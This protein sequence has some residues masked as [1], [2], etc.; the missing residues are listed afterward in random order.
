MSW[1]AKPAATEK[2][3]SPASMF[4]GLTDG[5]T[6]TIAAITAIESRSQPA[7]LLITAAKLGVRRTRSSRNRSHRTPRETR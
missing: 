4:T 7:S 5:K 6:T 2:K 1:K 3:P